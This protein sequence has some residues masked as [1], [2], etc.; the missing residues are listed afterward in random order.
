VK[1]GIKKKR[2]VPVMAAYVV[3]RFSVQPLLFYGDNSDLC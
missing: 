3:K 1:R 2:S